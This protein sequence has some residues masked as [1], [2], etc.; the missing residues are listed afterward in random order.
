MKDLGNDKFS[1]DPGERIKIRT[2]VDKPPCIVDFSDPIG[3][4]WENIQKVPPCDQREFTA[5]QAKGA[6]FSFNVNCGVQIAEGDP[7]PAA[8]YT[9]TFKSITNPA[10]PAVDKHI[11]VAAGVVGRFF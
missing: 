1:V 4:A 2:T 11:D 10:D 3:G 5:S 8:H 9:L 6:A 7:D